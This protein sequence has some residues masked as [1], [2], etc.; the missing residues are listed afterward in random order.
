MSDEDLVPGFACRCLR[1]VGRERSAAGIEERN[2]KLHGKG[3][4][5]LFR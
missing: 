1:S 5:G 2:F 3:F 4:G